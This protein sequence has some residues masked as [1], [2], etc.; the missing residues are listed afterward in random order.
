MT[1]RKNDDGT[2]S[3]D[4]FTDINT[5]PIARETDLV[6]YRDKGAWRATLIEPYERSAPPPDHVPTTA[7][8]KLEALISAATAAL[9]IMRREP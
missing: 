7:A 1:W 2:F 3:H 4:T 6:V 9:D 5:F 8:T